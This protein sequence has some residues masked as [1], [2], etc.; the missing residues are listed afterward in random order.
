MFRSELDFQAHKKQKHAKTKSEVRAYSKINIEFNQG[1]NRHRRGAG[2]G[3]GAHSNHNN[4]R[5]DSNEE[6]HD[7]SNRINHNRRGGNNQRQ[8]AAVDA[9][10][11]RASR[12]Q[13][14][15]DNRRRRTEAERLK[16]QYEKYNEQQE[17]QPQPSGGLSEI[18]AAISERSETK[19]AEKSVVNEVPA[20]SANTT[21]RDLIG[22][23]SAPSINKDAEFPSLAALGAAIETTASTS[24]RPFP[25]ATT[26]SSKKQSVWEK[27]PEKS[28]LV[29]QENDVDQ[30]FSS[31][32]TKKKKNKPKSDQKIDSSLVEAVQKIGKPEFSILSRSFIKFKI[33]IRLKMK[34]LH[35]LKHLQVNQSRLFL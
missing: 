9:D 7:E 33:K 17:K 26:S 22:S 23:G 1:D 2:R 25:F 19:P 28:V 35:L 27:K 16:E 6:E 31:K 29:A 10:V 30:L 14:D 4:H 34:T 3:A 12:D 13:F 32:Q 18:A 20:A 8:N 15:D 24:S 11:M 5:S 21:W